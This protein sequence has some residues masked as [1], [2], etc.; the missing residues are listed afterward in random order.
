VVFE[1]PLGAAGASVYLL[2]SDPTAAAPLALESKPLL[3]DTSEMPGLH[4][5]A[6]I[7]E[8][9]IAALKAS[10]VRFR[11]GNATDVDGPW[12]YCD[13]QALAPD[14]RT[15]RLS[16]MPSGTYHKIVFESTANNWELDLQGF[17]FFGQVEGVKRDAI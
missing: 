7:D 4:I 3:I 6:K 15:Y 1:K 2:E 8:V 12:E 14:L 17:S 16:S 5:D 13:W 9:E 10:N 11:I